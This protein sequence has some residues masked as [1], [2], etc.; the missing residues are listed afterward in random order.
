MT[1]PEKLF[2]SCDWQ[3]IKA[4]ESAPLYKRNVLVIKGKQ[5]EIETWEKRWCLVLAN[6][7]TE[8][9][10]YYNCDSEK[11]C[12]FTKETPPTHWKPIDSPLADALRI[13]VMALELIDA[14]T[15]E[16][17]DK[18]LAGIALEQIEATLKG[19]E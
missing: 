12:Y 5:F 7:G 6:D 14:G 11:W 15:V 2:A 17:G 18:L 19:E 16:T 1:T 4:Y 9:L 13:A 3:P 8:Q 10:S